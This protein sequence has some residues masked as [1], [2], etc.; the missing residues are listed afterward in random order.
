MGPMGSLGRKLEYDF[1]VRYSIVQSIGI[2]D[3]QYP[4]LI[5]P[6]YLGVSENRGPQDSSTLNNRIPQ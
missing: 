6:L 5:R 1:G 4:K 2:G 3:G